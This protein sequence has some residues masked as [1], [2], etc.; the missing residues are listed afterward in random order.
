VCVRKTCETG[1]HSHFFH[2]TGDTP[3]T[4]DIPGCQTCKWWY[5]ASL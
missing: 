1:I 5:T 3:A 4:G 2:V